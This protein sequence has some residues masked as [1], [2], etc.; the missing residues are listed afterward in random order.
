MIVQLGLRS[1]Y[2]KPFWRAFKHA[3][4][5]GQIDGALGMGFIAHH[6]IK[7]TREALRGEQ[8]ASFYS[9]AQKPRP[10]REAQP[11]EAM[12]QSA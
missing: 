9:K 7:F 11:Q 3:L 4:R 12:R 5:R 1:D 10:G 6:L 8:N 2:R